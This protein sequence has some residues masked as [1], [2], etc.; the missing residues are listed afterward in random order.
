MT[1]LR[2]VG[3]LS[4]AN[5]VFSRNVTDLALLRNGAG[6]TLVSAT[7]LGGGV[8]S[9]QIAATAT[10]GL[11]ADAEGYVGLGR[12]VDPRSIM[13][14]GSVYA[15]GLA[16]ASGGGHQVNADG[17]LTPPASQPAQGLPWD[18]LT[19][20]EATVGGTGLVLAARND[21]ASFSSY[22]QTPS[23]L[24]HVA[25]SAMPFAV[26]DYARID[27]LTTVTVGGATYALALS[28][29][30]NT[31]VSQRLNADG[32]LGE[33]RYIGMGAQTPFRLP[34]EIDTVT[35]AGN[36]YVIVAGMG[37]NSLTVLRLAATGA[38][39]PVDHILDE[40]GT[41]FANVSEMAAVTLS[42]RSF[43]VV[44][45]SDDGLSLFTML[46]DGRLIHLDTI[47]DTAALS[48]QNVSALTAAS[49]GGKISVAAASGIEA[50]ISQF[51]IDPGPIGA[52]GWAGAG[53]VTGTGAND[54][55][56]AQDSTTV[57]RGGGGDDILASFRRAVTLVGGA[58]RDVFIPSAMT[59]TV[60]IADFN[61][62]EDRL[63]LSNLGFLRSI[64]QLTVTPTARGLD[65][66][67]GTTTIAVRSHDGTTLSA[68]LI[69]DS[70]FPIAH[71]P[72]GGGVQTVI[73]TEA[74]DAISSLVD[75]LN[76][77]GLGGN[78]T[79]TGSYLSDSMNGGD[80]NDRLYGRAGN[81]SLYGANG[82]DTLYGES[83]DDYLHGG[84]GNDAQFGGDGNDRVAGGTGDDTLDGSDGNDAVLGEGGNDLLYG[85]GGNDT[86]H[87]G[88]GNDTIYGNHGDD[89]LVESTGINILFG[90][91]GRD[92]LIGGIHADRLLG[93]DGDDIAFGLDGNDW[94]WG[95]WGDDTLNGGTGNDTIMGGPGNDRLLGAEGDDVIDGE[96]GD[97]VIFGHEGNDFIAGK[98]G[99]DIIY[100]EWGDDTLLGNE[101]DDLLHGGVG[102][103]RLI[104][105][106]GND[107][108][109]GAQGS[110][111]II[112]TSGAQVIFG[113]SGHDVIF[114]GSDADRIYGETENDVIYGLGG[115]DLV[116]GGAGDDMLRGGDGGDRMWGGDGNDRLFGEN[117]NDAL[118]GGTG[119]DLMDGGAGND[120]LSGDVGH[121][122]L[123]GGWGND[124]VMG[125]DDNDQLWGDGGND[126]LHGGNGRDRLQGGTGADT[127]IGGADHDVFVFTTLS[128]SNAGSGIDTIVD[129]TRGVDLL[130]LRALHLGFIGGAAFTGQAG[131]L[132]VQGFAGGCQL[133]GNLNGD[134]VTD[135]LIVL[136]APTLAASDMLL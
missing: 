136:N 25:T 1:V 72:A 92:T 11:A 76:A 42:G 51:E 57:I 133:Q 118:D 94:L 27:E 115:D 110:D 83:G 65:I 66:V 45:G 89:L 4:A 70:L 56:M 73:G 108:V 91:G 130:D 13:I 120:T 103:D 19:A 33:A 40:G 128:D 125:G 93:E 121:D 131:Q 116:D 67:Y 86:L 107:T 24:V 60:T 46:P 9:W 74:G 98:T 104:S 78:D 97:D 101:G 36:T 7:H 16:G 129:F 38:L 96:D 52:T 71:Y 81:D 126:W 63:D 59:G 88:D 134:G 39:T 34:T 64:A 90:G 18:T 114:G 105:G 132:R 22:R 75:A 55:L 82:N 28:T 111:T 35:V 12:I 61:P 3:T 37:S 44:G 127:L 80:G 6:L 109:Y 53:D 123:L 26:V 20:T 29:A 54:L 113:G 102:N 43:L 85:G 15:F 95:Q 32:S 68:G 69:N 100:G 17:S 77:Y 124:I 30:G 117:G 79:I 2:H 50:G 112:A 10:A 135:L 41:R 62:A 84:D 87:G 47:A 21:G 122:A 99:N 31:L 48:L 119:N 8:A 14:G 106:T 58:G 49:L 5:G 23:G